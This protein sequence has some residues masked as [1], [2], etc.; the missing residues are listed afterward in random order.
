LGQSGCEARAP[1][2]GGGCGAGDAAGAAVWVVVWEKARL[3]KRSE[4]PT[5]AVESERNRMKVS[6]KRREGTQGGYQSDGS[7]AFRVNGA[8][9]DSWV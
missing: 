5:S 6:K 8:L 4:A 3:H 7:F 1:T 9:Q 2:S